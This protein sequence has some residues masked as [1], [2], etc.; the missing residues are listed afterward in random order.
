MD[1]FFENMD[2][3]FNTIENELDYSYSNDSW[4]Y[5]EKMLDDAFLDSSFI[6]A[7]EQVAAAPI[8]DFSAIDDAFLDDAF[9]EASSNTK[10]NYSSHYFNDFKSK[11]DA[12]F[13]NEIFVSAA[14]ATTSNY[15]NEYWNAANIA[16]QNEGLHHEYKAEYWAE[17]E[18]LLVKDKRRGFFF[19][20]SSVAALLLLFSAIGLNQNSSNRSANIT[21]TQNKSSKQVQKKIQ[22]PITKSNHL[23][24]KPD[25]KLIESNKLKTNLNQIRESSVSSSNETTLKTDQ[26]IDKM[27]LM[28]RPIVETLNTDK[29]LD[30]S[31][32]ITTP[33]LLTTIE[34][35][36]SNDNDDTETSK[37]TIL[38]KIKAQK[39]S[40]IA[41][42]NLEKSPQLLKLTP[43]I[44][45]PIHEI[46]IKFEKGIGNVFTDDQTSFSSRNALYLDY[47]FTPIKILRQ[48]Q[49]GFETGLYHMNLDNLEYEQNYSIYQNHG[50]VDHY[51]AKMTYKDLVYISS[52]INTFY[53][54][55]KQHKVKIGFGVDKLMTSKIDMK[56]KANSENSVQDNNGEWGLNKGINTIDFTFGIGYE[57]VINTK[58]SVMFDSKFG[59]IDKTN[60]SYLRNTKMNRDLSLLFGL[61][62][63]IF[64]T[65]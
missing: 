33:P 38:S 26:A 50:G 40:H 18:K 24:S 20:W 7:A 58:F 64:A 5:A 37:H 43:I 52:S 22:E 10:T 34:N 30:N 62:Y 8:I 3:R 54:I 48:F 27:N 16:L 46:G 4:Q 36:A 51:W 44:I 29:I 59:T 14:K 61:K 56:Y 41:I 23:L 12:L 42:N 63:N 39:I 25:T 47:R 45:K 55:N 15:Q 9:V 49:F 2:K 13:Q 17:A 53:S 65:H 19:L 21:E 6:E 31:N 57:Y 1:K 28:D 60:N 35:V 11:E 32:Y